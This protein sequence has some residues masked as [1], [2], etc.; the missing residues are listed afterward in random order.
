MA[1]HGPAQDDFGR[2]FVYADKT[3]AERVAE[4]QGKPPPRVVKLEDATVEDYVRAEAE[5]GAIEIVKLEPPE[6]TE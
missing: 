3:V 6:A 1:E 4:L 5:P 2:R